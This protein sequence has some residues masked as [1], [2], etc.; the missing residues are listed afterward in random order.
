MSIDPRAEAR[1]RRRG[2][3]DACRRE[4]DRGR[5]SG[6]D[7]RRAGPTRHPRRA[8]GD[9]R[10][11]HPAGRLR[12]RR[13]QRGPRL[14][15]H[16]G[17]GRRRQ[18]R[19]PRHPARAPS[20]PIDPADGGARERR[21][22]GA[23]PVRPPRAPRP[24]RPR[25]GA[26]C[27]TSS[28]STAPTPG[29]RWT[30]WS[31]RCTTPT[32]CCAAPSS[33]DCP[34]DGRRPD[35]AHRR[36]LNRYAEQAGRAVVIAVER[37]ALAE[38]VRMLSADPRGGA[39]RRPRAQ[40]R[41]DARRQIQPSL[42]EG[43]RA[44]GMWIQ[45]F[46]E[47]GHGLGAIYSGD[48]AAVEMPPA[49]GPDRRARGRR[50]VAGPAGR[51]SSSRHRPRDA[52]RR[53]GLRAGV[54]ARSCDFLEGIGVGSLLFVPLGAGPRVPGQPGADPGARRRRSGP[55]PRSTRRS[56]SATTSAARSSTPAPS[57]A[58]ASWSR[59]LQAL[60]D[61]Q[62][63]ADR[64]RRPTSSRARWPRC[65]ANLEILQDAADLDPARRG[66]LARRG[67]RRRAGW[68]GWSRTCCCSPRSATRHRR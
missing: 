46:D 12:G 37:E 41:R 10:G 54:R 39:Q 40:H 30:C 42:I 18:R 3:V 67:P 52:A 4:P 7:G 13:G 38:Q 32:A 1:R 62:E 34:T 66:V 23:V 55:R 51:R 49:P 60:D 14:P 59:E 33:I 15:A 29:T 8:A 35:E 58:S 61:L 20:R 48:G 45:T 11:R 68:C 27:P 5:R 9:R 43:F 25:P 17:D 47:D 28:R 65:S 53:A 19:G 64:D 26:G 56:T 31:P 22:L 44:L 6:A 21:G 36:I 57:S 63:Q 2:A 24:R 50:L 16:A